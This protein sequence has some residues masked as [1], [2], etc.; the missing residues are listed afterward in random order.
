L[1]QIASPLIYLLLGAAL[2]S[3]LTSDIEDALFIVVVL[4][5]N[6]A[7][8]SVQEIRAEFNTASLRAAVRTTSRVLRS[9]TVILIDA[10]RLVPGDIAVVEAGDRVPADARLLEAT[11]I[12]ADESALTGES[13]PVD[14]AATGPQPIGT[15]LG[16]RLGLI[17]A[18]TTL[19]RGQALAVVVATGAATAFGRIARSLDQPAE[20]AP[21]TRR[22]E[23]FTRMLGAVS[24]A[25]V[26]VLVAAL[27]AAGQPLAQTVLVGVA[28]AV[29]V[30]PE[31]MPVAV[32]VALSIAIRR[33][34]RRNVIVRHLAAVEGLGSCTVIAT[35]KTGTLTLNQL[36]AKRVWLPG[37]G[38]VDLDGEGYDL[39]GRVHRNGTAL[40]AAARSELAD[41]ARAVVFCNE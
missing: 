13:L 1:G 36:T 29:S 25:V 28:L 37:H 41:L 5:I 7:I 20:T 32:T 14:K 16:D 15:P 2:V 23:R 35:D 9:G 27:L 6:T 33:M 30:I 17:H 22:L 11:E 3:L 10:A 34:A 21:L 18:G 4:T 31:G 19:R 38:T 12:Q 24:V 8:G 39:A 40:D 26:A